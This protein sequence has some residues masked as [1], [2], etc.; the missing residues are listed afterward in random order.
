MEDVIKALGD[1][2]LLVQQFE[3]LVYELFEKDQWPKH[4]EI[5]ELFNLPAPLNFFQS[6]VSEHKEFEKAMFNELELIM[7]R[8]V[9]CSIFSF[10]IPT[11]EALQF[12]TSYQPILEIGAGSGFWA[13]LLK[14]NNCDIIA[15]TIDNE[16][17]P[18]SKKFSEIEYLPAI[19]AIKKYPD[20][21]VLCSWPSVDNW[22]EKALPYIKNNL[23]L[24]GELE[25]IASDKFYDILEDEFK[26]INT[27]P[28]PRWLI[29]I[30]DVLN[31][32]K[33]IND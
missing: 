25:S 19:D 11:L 5:K 3:G 26:E 33:R 4:E 28:L 32:Y 20:R 10:S 8:R 30:K 17:Y 21:T 7:K 9:M 27:H 14:R 2:E 12:I 18:F 22:V 23:I 24:T 16:S 31:V 15:T 29:L 13:A 1:T 6:G